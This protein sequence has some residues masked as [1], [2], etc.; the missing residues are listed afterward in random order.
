MF[1][2]GLQSC[3]SGRGRDGEVGEATDPQPFLNQ[4]I[5]TFMVTAL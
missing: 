4:S 2:V 5:L 3:V 1:Q